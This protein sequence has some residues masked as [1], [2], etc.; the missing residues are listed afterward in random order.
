MLYPDIYVGGTYN[1]NIHQAPSGTNRDSGGSVRVAPRMIATYTDGAI[2][3]TMIFGVGDFQ[4]FNGDT[5]SA[6][7]GISHNYKPTQ[8]VTFNANFRFTRETDLFTSALNFNN[9]AIGPS[10]TPSVPIPIIINPFGTSPTVNPTAYNQFTAGVSAAK[11]FGEWFTSVSA[12]AFRIAFDHNNNVPF[13]F[14][15][16]N[17]STSLWLA[18]RIGYHFVPGLYAFVEGDGVWQ[19][20]E[21]SIFDTNGYRAL[22]GIGTDDPNS[23]VRGEGYAGYQFQHQQQDTVPYIGIPQDANSFV[24]G[25]RVYYYP[26][27]FWTLIGSADQVLSMSTILSPG[28]PAGVPN[29]VTTLLLQTTYGLSRQWSIGGRV[30]YARSDYID[31]GR[32][33]NAW[34][35]G[36]SLNYEIWRNLAFTLDYQWTTSNSNIPFNDFTK[37]VVSAGLTYWY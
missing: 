16:S 37:N 19:R 12:T 32:L 23:L 20:F 14:A 5:I 33:D 26:T 35:L 17:D 21:N 36:A 24:F 15:T 7:A 22:G 30:G 9:N 25:G 13:P 34:M 18:G 3:Q 10:G 11:S 28:F 2:H 31:F 27:R 1:S 29:R 8:D 6:D 4:F